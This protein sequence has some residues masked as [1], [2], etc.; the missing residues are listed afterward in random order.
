M[1][2]IESYVFF[3]PT[4]LLFKNKC[5]IPFSLKLINKKI[6]PLLESCVF[7][8]ASI[9]LPALQGDYFPFHFTAKKDG[10]PNAAHPYASVIKIL[11]TAPAPHNIFCS[12]GPYAWSRTARLH[13]KYFLPVDIAHLYKLFLTGP[14]VYLIAVL[15]QPH[16]VVRAF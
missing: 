9:Y 12:G 6:H 2:E 16:L 11:E 7:P 1:F 8:T 10:L 3:I 14:H 5:I 15:V 13:A 4:F